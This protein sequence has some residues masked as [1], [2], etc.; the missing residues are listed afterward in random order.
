MVPLERWPTILTGAVGRCRLFNEVR[1][2]AETASTQD[3]ARELAPHSGLIVT[4]WRQTGGRGRLGR[5]WADTGEDGVAVTFIAPDAPPERL[6]VASAVAVARTVAW[7]A[8]F[9]STVR[10]GIKW[11]ND[12]VV[13]RRKLAGILIERTRGVALIGIGLNVGQRSFDGDLATTATSVRLLG[14]DV[15][16]CAV[17]E[18]LMLDVDAAL[19]ENPESLA[20]AYAERDAL[21][22]T[23]AVF[24][25][26]EGE[27][28]GLV[29]RVSPFEGIV[30]A[31]DGVERCLA[32]ATTTVHS[33]KDGARR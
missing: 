27:V 4:S 6:A 26:P 25:T 8:R 1:V 22:G 30:V 28:A 23:H 16:R 17:L 11:P 10:V 29:L 18:H 19:A 12:V 13:E 7:C 24:G 5:T 9:D 2:L 3:A 31:C 33:W 15:D 14:F 32:A 20:S 21:R